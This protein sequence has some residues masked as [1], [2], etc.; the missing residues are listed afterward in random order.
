LHP[1][2]HSV[3]ATVPDPIL[4]AIAAHRRV[5]AELL[6]LFEAQRAADEAVQQANA[7]A[8]P[9]LEARLAEL[10]RAEGPRG[11]LEKRAS[12]RMTTTVPTTLDG[13]VAVLRYLRDLFERDGYAPFEDDERAMARYCQA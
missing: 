3:T 8:R 2:H 1:E 7:L 6:K 4:A 9:A 12:R 5:Y 11:R 13:A 10:C